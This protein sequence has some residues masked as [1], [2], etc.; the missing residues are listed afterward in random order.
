[1]TKLVII[2]PISAILKNFF[3]HF[4][5]TLQSTNVPNVMSK[6]FSYQDYAGE[7]GGQYVTP[8]GMIRQKYP[9]P[10]RVKIK[11]GILINKLNLMLMFICSAL[12]QKYPLCGKFCPENQNCLLQMKFGTYFNSNC[13]IWKWFSIFFLFDCI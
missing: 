12:D 13:W 1:M 6:A 10:V 3:Y 11:L 9:R 8:R 2:I 7:E 4:F 5:V